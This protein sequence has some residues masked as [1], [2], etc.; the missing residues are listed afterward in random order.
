MTV[1]QWRAERSPTVPQ[2][3]EEMLQVAPHPTLAYVGAD[4]EW[5]DLIRRQS[6]ALPCRLEIVPGDYAMAFRQS[7]N[8]LPR[9][10]TH[11]DVGELAR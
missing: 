9:V 11:L 2:T 7:G 3:W 5:H 4:D 8:V 10:L 1:E 6:A